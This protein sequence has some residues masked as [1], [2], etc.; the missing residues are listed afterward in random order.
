M[1]AIS[2][3]AFKLSYSHIF[4]YNVIRCISIK[5]LIQ[6]SIL[7]MRSKRPSRCLSWQGPLDTLSWDDGSMASLFLVSYRVSL[8]S[9]YYCMVNREPLTLKKKDQTILRLLFEAYVFI[10]LYYVSLCYRICMYI[11]SESKRW[12]VLHLFC[13]VAT[14]N[15]CLWTIIIFD[16][17]LVLIEKKIRT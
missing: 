12:S 13:Y 5:G 1:G 4:H 9:T 7:A 11:K 17:L 6:T 10:D 15:W 8:V 3:F 2:C 14:R 16:F